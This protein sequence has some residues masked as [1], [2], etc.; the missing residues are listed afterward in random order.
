ML[1]EPWTN[2]WQASCSKSQEMFKDTRVT[3]H[4]RSRYPIF[5]SS[6]TWIARAPLV[7]T[8]FLGGRDGLAG[9]FHRG[10]TFSSRTWLYQFSRIEL[11]EGNQ[12]SRWMSPTWPAPVAARDGD[13]NESLRHRVHLV[14]W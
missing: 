4:T 7:T 3:R 6:M 5:Q 10:D 13:A 2:E 14:G 1:R 9:K 11:A 12:R 8:V